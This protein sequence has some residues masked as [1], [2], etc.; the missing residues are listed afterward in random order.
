MGTQRLKRAQWTFA[1]ASKTVTFGG[2]PGFDIVGLVEI[3][4]P[5]K[6]LIYDGYDETGTLGGTVSGNVLTLQFDTTVA[7]FS[8]G[9]S[10]RIIYD[11][12]VPDAQNIT[13]SATSAGA[14]TAFA[15]AGYGGI[16][17]EIISGAGTASLQFNSS[18]DG[19][20]G[21][22]TSGLGYV[23]EDSTVSQATAISAITPRRLFRAMDGLWARLNIVSVAT[24]PLIVSVSRRVAWMSERGGVVSG[25]IT[26][27]NSSATVGGV[28]AFASALSPG[29]LSSRIKSNASTNAALVKSAA[30]NLYSGIVSNN[31][32]APAYIKFYDTASVPAVGTTVPVV[33]IMV[34]ANAFLSIDRTI[35][36]RFMTG[37]AYSIS[38]G[39]S[40]ADTS[41]IAA[42]QVH[43]ELIY[44]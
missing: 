8:A 9:D 6:G 32:T 1:P 7:G 37:I 43:G 20:S 4:H 22:W 18:V 41:A 34:P 33:T 42:D 17:V 14:Q 21:S 12:Q 26:L 3:W 25:N 13:Y 24:S 10:L 40:D 38:G 30:G 5:T 44:I 23:P 36:R 16:L 27:N 39:A 28:L 2:V 35:A 19:M 31:G 29:A 15:T 11:E